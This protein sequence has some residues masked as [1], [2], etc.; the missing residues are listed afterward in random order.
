MEVDSAR[1][2]NYVKI[3]P[4][5]SPMLNQTNG[6]VSLRKTKENVKVFYCTDLICDLFVT[7]DVF[8]SSTGPTSCVSN[9]RS[10]RDNSGFR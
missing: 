5:I 2:K 4:M 1:R 6:F 8:L 7:I 9:N 10:V 3:S